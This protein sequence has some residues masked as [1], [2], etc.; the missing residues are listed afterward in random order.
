MAEVQMSSKTGK[1]KLKPR[2][3]AYTGADDPRQSEQVKEAAESLEPVEVKVGA[4]DLKAAMEHVA[5]KKKCMDATPLQKMYRRLSE[6]KPGDFIARLTEMQKL[7]GGELA[8]VEA[9][10]PVES[11]KGEERVLDLLERWMAE[12]KARE[13]GDGGEG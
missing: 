2:G 5:C 9:A 3:K 10:A 4:E 8:V 11:D 1:P 13:A 6:E 12:R 7:A